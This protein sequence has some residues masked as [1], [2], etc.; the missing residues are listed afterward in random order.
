MWR[1]TAFYQST[2]VTV[3]ATD[4]ETL[5]KASF[6]SV[7]QSAPSNGSTNNPKVPWGCVYL[8]KSG[9]QKVC[10]HKSDDELKW[11]VCLVSL[12]PLQ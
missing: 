12:T 6:H 2:R 5:R 10:S 11:H 7:S 9:S 1:K 4:S 3:T 8:S